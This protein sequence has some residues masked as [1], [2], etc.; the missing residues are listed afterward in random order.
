MRTA[1]VGG[2]IVRSAST[3]ARSV[4]DDAQSQRKTAAMTTSVS[5]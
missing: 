5:K 1:R 2:K 4:P 3:L